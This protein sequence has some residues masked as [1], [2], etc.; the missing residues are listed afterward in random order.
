M[1]CS[2]H[3]IAF[4]APRRRPD[5]GR[6]PT[7]RVNMYSECRIKIDVERSILVTAALA[8]IAFSLNEREECGYMVMSCELSQMHFYYLYVLDSHSVRRLF[9]ISIPIWF[10]VFGVEYQ[11]PRKLEMPEFRMDSKFCSYVVLYGLFVML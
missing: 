5:T 1:S 7:G 9:T 10:F 4:Q 2:S 6:R 11:L 8:Y 3:S